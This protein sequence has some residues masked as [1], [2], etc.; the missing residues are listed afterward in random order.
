MDVAVLAT[1]QITHG[2][3]VSN[4]RLA[5]TATHPFDKQSREL[6]GQI[7]TTITLGDIN[8]GIEAR[9]CKD[10]WD[11]VGEAEPG[12]IHLSRLV[13]AL[14][15]KYSRSLPQIIQDDVVVQTLR[16]EFSTKTT[17]GSKSSTVLFT[18][19]IDFPIT[20]EPNSQQ[21]RLRFDAH[22]TDEPEKKEYRHEFSG[23]LTL[24]PVGF[25]TKYSE[26]AKASFF[27]AAYSDSKNQNIKLKQLVEHVS[28]TLANLIPDGL[29]IVVKDAVFAFDKTGE[30][31]RKF[32]FGTDLAIQCDFSR[33]PLV[34]KYFSGPGAAK[35]GV[36]NLKIVFASKPFVAAEVQNLNQLLSA[37]DPPVSKLPDVTRT[38]TPDPGNATQSDATTPVLKQGANIAAVLNLG[39][40]SKPL[41]F[42]ASPGA[43]QSSS[44]GQ[45]IPDTT[46]GDS[47]I[48]LNIQKSIGPVHFER[49]GVEYRQSKLWVLLS[50]SLTA[51]GL[52]ISLD[53]LSLGT[54]LDAFDLKPALRGLGIDYRNDFV[55]IGGS[56]SVVPA[57][58]P[59]SEPEYSG[60][61]TLKARGLTI[62][63]V[64]K[65]TTIDQHPSLFIFG[66]LDYPIGG[67]PFFFVTGLAAG[68][69]YQRAL[70]IP[71]IDRIGQFSLITAAQKNSSFTD[72][73]QNPNLA[74]EIPPAAGEHFLAAGVLFT[75]F[76]LVESTVLL[77]VAFGKRFELHLLGLSKM[78][79]PAALEDAA[80]TAVEPVAEV[81]L[82]VKGS[83]IP[84]DGFLELRA[85][86]T[87]TS[88]LFSKNCH[89]TGGFAFLCWF[90]PKPG[91]ASTG[92]EGDFVLTLGGYHP[93]FHVP[94]NYPTVPR[95]GFNWQVT[96]GNTQPPR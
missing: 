41:S 94:S 58:D 7:D 63:A 2:F 5:F 53:G 44:D 90:K 89:L 45:A 76:K 22:F 39:G 52:K 73:L 72:V 70:A 40:S 66:L 38:D 17:D 56:F 11:F 13:K 47:A 1:C 25:G 57:K 79:M 37:F 10:G 15:T 93:A 14:E 19:E 26:D 32:L 16:L 86:L 85:Q 49:V 29:G 6:T 42:P 8:F 95:L 12:G 75:S 54:P 33:L 59:N 18:S 28:S 21:G 91:V 4:P 71:T 3:D 78:R 88:Y 51:A 83:F 64:G 80:S 81:E 92:P 61:V 96:P 24:G 65:Y 20:S 62:S 60:A 27:V 84:D 30:D 34:G 67:P 9:K 35:I 31:S 87:P 43:Q 46:T 77:F 74:K 36:D 50:A 23:E 69:G 68:F 55:E 48:W 82:A